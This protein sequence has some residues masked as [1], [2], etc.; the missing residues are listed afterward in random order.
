M[1]ISNRFIIINLFIFFFLSLFVGLNENIFGFWYFLSLT[2]LWILVLYSNELFKSLLLIIV[3]A[4][5]FFYTI[6]FFITPI[7]QDFSR[8]LSLGQIDIE[9]R[10]SII[11]Q[12]TSF[13]IPFCLAIFIISNLFNFRLANYKYLNFKRIFVVIIILNLI[14]FLVNKNF[15]DQLFA[16]ILNLI[17]SYYRL[18]LVFLLLIFFNYEQILNKYKVIYSSIY[19]IL[20][21]FLGSREGIL[22]LFYTFFI[23]FRLKFKKINLS[24]NLFII[25]IVFLLSIPLIVFIGTAVR[26]NIPLS[27]QNFNQMLLGTSVNL[28]GTIFEFALMRLSGLD[29]II[30]SFDKGYVF[31]K[32]YNFE[33]LIKS[34][35]D[36]FIPGKIFENLPLTNYINLTRGF[37]EIEIEIWYSSKEITFTGSLFFLAGSNILLTY[38]LSFIFGV[39]ISILF[40]LTNKN[41][42]MQIAFLYGCFYLPRSLSVDDTFIILINLLLGA[43]IISKS[44]F[45]LNRLKI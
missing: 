43:L 31:E 4:I 24:L 10:Y 39:I 13:Y 14:K 30:W 32:F 6:S 35:I 17:T 36:Y 40:L 20:T 21:S 33:T 5:S 9:K 23:T 15:S 18:D 37:S 34:I 42:Y 16:K 11:A 12:I 44:A 22:R 26:Y 29:E 19:L 1:L 38:V 45:F 7:S 8:Y 2:L 28:D 41:A 27:F 3:I 25:F